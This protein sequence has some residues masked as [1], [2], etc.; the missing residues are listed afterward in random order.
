MEKMMSYC[1]LL[2]N[3]CKAYEATV[4]NDQKLKEELAAEWSKM[5][6]AD[7]KPEHINCLGCKSEV[8]IA[9]CSMCEARA[10]NLEKKLDNCSQCGLFAC[11]KLDEI[12]KHAPDT[13]ERLMQMRK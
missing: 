9:Y 4:N 1:G 12:F 2:C 7:I 11:G 3:E 13:R 8:T 6:D 5:Y 10:C